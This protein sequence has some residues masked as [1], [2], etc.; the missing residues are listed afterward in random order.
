MRFEI[1]I[2]CLSAVPVTFFSIHF[3][4]FILLFFVTFNIGFIT[5]AFLS[6]IISLVFLIFIFLISSDNKIHTIKK[7]EN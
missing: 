1:L 3:L 6:G 7:E 5:L 4:G 2:Q